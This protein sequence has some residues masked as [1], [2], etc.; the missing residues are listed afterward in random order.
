[1]KTYALLL[2]TALVNNYRAVKTKYVKS[3]DKKQSAKSKLSNS[4]NGAVAILGVGIIVVL[5]SLMTHSIAFLSALEGLH[6]Q[7]LSSMLTAGQITILILGFS[8]VTS[9][10]YFSKDNEFLSSLP[11]SP[12]TIFS[13]KLTVVYLNDML[14]GAVFLLPMLIS[15]VVGVLQ[16]GATLPMYF[17]FMIPVVIL[18]TPI[19]PLAIISIL[20]FPMIKIV[21]YFKNKSIVTLVLSV[22]MFLGF[23]ALYMVFVKN[24]E[25]LLGQGATK[26][27]PKALAT[28]IIALDKGVFYNR[29]FALA[30]TGT[31]FFKN[32]LIYIAVICASV[33]VV[34]AL[35]AVLYKKS[36]G[37]AGEETRRKSKDRESAIILSGKKKA[38]FMREIKCLLRSQSFAF[39]SIMGSL[40]PPLIVIV[41]HSLGLKSPTEQ[42]GQAVSSLARGFSGIGVTF[43]YSLMMICGMNYTASLAISREGSTFYVLRYIPVDFSEILKTKIKVANAVS[44]VGV[45]LVCVASLAVT[46]GDFANVLP[47]TLALF[48][49]AYAFNSICVF[50]DLKKPNVT[51]TSPYEVIKRNFYPTVPMFYAMG[52]GIGFMVIMSVIAKYEKAINIKLGVSLFWIITIIIGVVMTVIVNAVMKKKAQFFFDRININ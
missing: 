17:Y 7:L 1:M 40:V 33:G 18:T 48:V 43:F 9:N 30:L 34:T 52:L 38:L 51:W 45:V 32:I 36:A 11:V 35:S 49:Y 10:M 31:A 14:V 21:S 26:V 8:S 2:K 15:Y 5:M 29:F 39:N 6:V 20:S 46:K 12:E 42:A 44:Y 27:L 41:M 28:A 19:T 22:L 24:M 25:K 37:K 4:I 13:V 47:M 16:A 3:D 50:R 23:F